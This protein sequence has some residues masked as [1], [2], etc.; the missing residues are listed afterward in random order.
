M[1]IFLCSKDNK[2]ARSLL[3]VALSMFVW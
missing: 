2:F 3:H 1:D